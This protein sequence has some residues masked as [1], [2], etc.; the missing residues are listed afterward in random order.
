MMLMTLLEQKQY[1]IVTSG[2]NRPCTVALH[3]TVD[4]VLKFNFC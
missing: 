3:S 2:I 4:A 1:R